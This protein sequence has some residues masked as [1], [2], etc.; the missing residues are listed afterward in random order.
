MDQV[1]VKI[2]QAQEF[3]Q[4]IPEQALFNDLYKVNYLQEERPQPVVDRC[5]MPDQYKIGNDPKKY[6]GEAM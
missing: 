1:L 4:R 2:G 6:D 5:Y 3:D